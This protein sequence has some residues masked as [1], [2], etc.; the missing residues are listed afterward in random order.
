MKKYIK[1]SI[2][3]FVS[4]IFIDL[5][6]CDTIDGL[7]SIRIDINDVQADGKSMNIKNNKVIV[8]AHTQNVSIDIHCFDF[9][10]Q[11]LHM[12]YKLKGVDRKEIILDDIDEVIN[13]TNLK[14]GTYIYNYKVYDE[15][16]NCLAQTKIM[17]QK[18]YKFYEEPKVRQLFY[19]SI[20]VIMILICHLVLIKRNKTIKD[21]QKEIPELAFKD[22]LTGVNNQNAFEYIKN[23]LKMDNMYAFLSV[24]VNHLD[25]LKHKYGNVCLEKIM[26]QA[27]KILQ[28]NYSKEIEIYRVSENLFYLLV[29]KP[30]Q[31][32][33]YIFESKQMFKKLGETKHLP[34]SF[35]IGIVYNNASH[36]NID[37][38]FDQCEQ[39]RLLDEKHAEKDFIESKVRL[40]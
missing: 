29:K 37:E 39:M 38:I 22:L 26:K 21:N 34:L 2:I 6:T 5:K 7:E 10:Q 33:N 18:K 20:V 16:S 25:Y 32:E 36:N 9:D 30:I 24:S 13:Y 23:N 40:L 14:G 1:I 8:P 15:N 31:I 17:I 28:T 12:V 35:S 11:N 27:V 3:L 4:M 19:F